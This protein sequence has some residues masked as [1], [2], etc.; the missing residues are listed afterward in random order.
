MCTRGEICKLIKIII[1]LIINVCLYIWSI[2]TLG[3]IQDEFDELLSGHMATTITQVDDVWAP[4]TITCSYNVTNCTDKLNQYPDITHTQAYF[5][6]ISSLQLFYD[7][8]QITSIDISDTRH[9]LFHL[10]SITVI[11]GVILLSCV[12]L[13][14]IT[15]SVRKRA[16]EQY[17]Q[18]V[19]INDEEYI[20]NEE[21]EECR[22]FVAK[23]VLKVTKLLYSFWLTIYKMYLCNLFSIA[24]I[25]Q[26]ILMLQYIPSQSM[27]VFFGVATGLC[28]M[29]IICC[30]CCICAWSDDKNKVMYGSCCCV[31]LIVFVLLGLF[32]I[33]SWGMSLY[34]IQFSNAYKSNVN[35]ILSPK[36]MGYTDL[37][38]TIAT[39]FGI[40]GWIEL[41]Y[42][43][44]ETCVMSVID[45]CK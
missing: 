25:N 6:G 14:Q 9:S 26:E 27:N 32:A 13:A 28:V 38:A 15:E 4:I 3:H 21:F 1:L 36:Y 34:A 2:K 39:F 8:D 43:S 44:I 41:T 11:A 22:A 33:P 30:C 5:S 23:Y 40:L 17:L 45:H 19:S 29:L 37:L 7:D 31:I 24:E 35:K 12:D 20:D 16:R 10:Y 18:M 42:D